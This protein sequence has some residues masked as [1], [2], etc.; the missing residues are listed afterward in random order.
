MK[1]CKQCRVEL[2]PWM[3]VCPLCEVAVADGDTTKQIRNQQ[4]PA[5]DERKPGLLK[6][7]F[8]QIT[9]VLLLSGILATVIINLAMVGRV[10]WSVYPMTICAIVLSYVFSLGLW[11][12][13]LLLQIATGWVASTA[14]LALVQWYIGDDW[15]LRLALPILCSINVIIMLLALILLNLSVKGLNIVAILF[16]GAA[17]LC[18]AVEAILSRYFQEEFRL[19]WS[20]VVSACLLPVT[21]I[22]VFM[23][24]KTRNNA[25]LEKI[26][27]T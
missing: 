1:I 7:I 22:I 20:V 27:H 18:L 4:Y 17:V 12:T 15:P 16:I 5:Y 23:H 3:D 6:R 19:S 25:D 11:T 14:V 8:L 9:C 10:T 26:F 24:F 2:E 21:A 13:K